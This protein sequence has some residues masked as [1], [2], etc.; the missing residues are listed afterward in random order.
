MAVICSH[1]FAEVTD[2]HRQRS[3]FHLFPH[4]LCL[5]GIVCIH[6]AWVVVAFPGSRGDV[7]KPLLRPTLIH[8]FYSLGRSCWR[9]STWV[10]RGRKELLRHTGDLND[11][12]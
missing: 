6:F 7:L 3:G 12:D 10:L 4:L 9:L 2:L 1:K 11:S 8:H 5:N